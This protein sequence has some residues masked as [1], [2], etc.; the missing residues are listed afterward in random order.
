MRE[1]DG[2][3]VGEDVGGDGVVHGLEEGLSV[4]FLHGRDQDGYSVEDLAG[5]YSHGIGGLTQCITICHR[6]TLIGQC[7]TCMLAIHGIG[8]HGPI[9]FTHCGENHVLVAILP[10]YVPTGSDIHDDYLNAVDHLPLLLCGHI[11][12]V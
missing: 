2:L 4:T 8:G 6:T 11:R 5:G 1:W 12:D 10:I 3:T 9:H 7:H